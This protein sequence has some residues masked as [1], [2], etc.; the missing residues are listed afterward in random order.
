MTD[1][2]KSLLFKKYEN[3]SLLVLN[4][5]GEWR[6]FGEEIKGYAEDENYV[7]YREFIEP[8]KGIAFAGKNKKSLFDNLA[9]L[10]SL[11]K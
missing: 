7:Y 3:V 5:W 11:N 9:G 4:D 2:K 1:T 6:E 10:F 8:C